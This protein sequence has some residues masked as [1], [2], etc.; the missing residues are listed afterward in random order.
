MVVSQGQFNDF[1][2]LDGGLWAGQEGL[3][4][5]H[6]RP[7][8][9]EVLHTKR[10]METVRGRAVRIWLHAQSRAAGCS[11]SAFRVMYSSRH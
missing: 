4:A 11:S 1:E 9:I 8:G 10:R 5:A 3:V 7:I 6:Q 2:L